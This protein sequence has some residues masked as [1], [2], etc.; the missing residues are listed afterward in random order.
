MRFPS[1]SVGGHC[2]E[3]KKLRILVTSGQPAST[4]LQSELES[5]GRKMG[6][7]TG[8]HWLGILSGGNTGAGPIDEQPE[9]LESAFRAG[10]TLT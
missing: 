4:G 8:M 7:F 2:L 1:I 10:Q 5:L 9:V 3:G 6:D